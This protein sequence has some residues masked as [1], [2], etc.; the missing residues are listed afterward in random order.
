MAT[1]LHSADATARARVG[2]RQPVPKKPRGRVRRRAVERH[3]R[4]GK[5]G[6]TDDVGAPT[7]AGDWRHLDQVLLAGNTFLKT[8][9]SAIHSQLW[10]VRECD[11]IY[12]TVTR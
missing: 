1:I 4:G 8:M 6:D 7:I 2:A 11:G 5:S 12:G 10:Q 9:N 3:Q